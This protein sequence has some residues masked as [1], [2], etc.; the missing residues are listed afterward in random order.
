V[1]DEETAGAPEGVE[2]IRRLGKPKARL[3][4]TIALLWTLP[5]IGAVFLLVRDTD[6]L[7]AAESVPMALERVTFEQWVALTI[8]VAHGAFLWLGRHY[9]KHEPV[10]E[11]LF[12][13]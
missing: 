3:F 5:S 7:L 9:R 10:R 8:L 13:P 1:K 12:E 11:E 6:R 4:R 2:V